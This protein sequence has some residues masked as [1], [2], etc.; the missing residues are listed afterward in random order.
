MRH[1]LGLIAAVLAAS[2]AGPTRA[3]EPEPQFWPLR[4][5]NF[6]VSLEKVRELH[7]KTAKVGFYVARDRGRFERV[8]ERALA[9]L[10]V[11][12]AARDSRGFRYTAPAD[13]EYS[14]SIQLVYT[15]GEV[16][17]RDAD[18]TAHRRVVIDTH[19]PQV[20][21]AAAGTSGVE[22]DV[23]DEYA[24]RDGVELQVRYRG[25]QQWTTVTPRAFGLRDRYTWE[26][27]SAQQPIEVRVVARDR[28]GH[29]GV[30]VPPFVTLP[31]GRSAPGLDPVRPA[32]D[33]AGAGFGNPDDFPTRPEISYVSSRN[34]VIE[35]KLTRITRSGIGKVHL[36]INDGKSGWKLAKSQ[37]E[38]IAATD[39]DPT[40]RIPHTVEKDGLYGF[41]V[42][43]ENKA[44]GKQDDPRPGDPAQFLIEV[45]ID[46]P[47]VKVKGHK[48]SPGGTVGPRVEIE[49]E[50]TDKNLW[51]EP[52]T[53]YYSTDKTE[54][55][56]ITSGRLRNSGRY[57]WEVEDKNL[58]RVYV[59]ATVIDKASNRSEHVYEKEILID[60]EKPA[61]VIEKVQGTG[62]QSQTERDSHRPAVEPTPTSPVVPSAPTPAPSGGPVTLPGLPDPL[63]K[64]PG[65]S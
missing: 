11:I 8:A 53:L 23:S 40:V 38:N 2:A 42:I 55:K 64:D 3:Q 52:I 16:N 21:I 9:D 24:K 17:P 43:P 1:R 45:D 58:W 44:G 39:G 18:L 12:D 41:I 27:L 14:F 22:W 65:K 19:P 56:P 63:P 25:T 6:P 33:R 60:L 31:A 61:A 47:F 4:E 36:W 5:I 13:G 51:E 37:T 34:L 29:E 62:G 20:R 49:W 50:A 57:V 48:V 10:D 15:D 59:R 32:S 35:S 54:W 46:K 30:S 28:T 26:G 7:P